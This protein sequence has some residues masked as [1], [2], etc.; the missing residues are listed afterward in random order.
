[1]AV[2]KTRIPEV[3]ERH[4]AEILSDWMKEQTTAGTQRPDLMKESELRQESTKF[5]T[6]LRE[7]IAGNDLMDIQR[8]NWGP[9]REFLSEVSRSRAIQGFS[10]TETATF[11]LSLKQPLF[12][13]LRKI[14]DGQPDYLFED[15]W[16][17]T[18]LL[19][20]LGLYSV[21][22]FQKTREDV[23]G[24]QQ[25]EMFEL[26][27]PVVELWQGILGLPIIGTLDSK[28]SQQVMETLLTRL[29]ETQSEVAVID[30]TGVPVMDTLTAQLSPED[31]QRH[32]PHGRRVHHLRHPAPDCPDPRSPGCQPGRRHHQGLVGRS[33][34]SRVQADGP[35][36]GSGSAAKRRPRI[37]ERPPVERIPILR[38]GEFL[39]VTIQ[40]DMHDR[41]ATMLMDDLTNRISATRRAGSPD[42]HLGTGHGGLLHRPD[43]RRHRADGAGDGRRDG[44]G[45]H[46][47]VG[48]HHAGRDG[49]RDDRRPHG[50]ERGEGHGASSRRDGPGSG[51]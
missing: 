31:R 16:N 25:Q 35:G 38:M 44:A 18:V 24:R 32:S 28:R 50:P 19:D 1:M 21:E 30:I 17:A 36:R 39:L 26:S 6:L 27:T 45:R 22:A 42:R 7:A 41:L 10:T 13:R 8:P 47:A 5:L 3:L 23:I 29:A 14:H 43:A 15:L 2:M 49:R 37:A 9:V 51:G 20:K 11:V 4:E 48:G 46:A 40:V 33:A 34:R 12:T